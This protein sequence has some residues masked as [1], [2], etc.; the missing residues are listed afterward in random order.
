MTLCLRVLLFGIGMSSAL[1]GCT[2]GGAPEDLAPARSLGVSLSGNAVSTA[3]F[4]GR[5]LLACFWTT[6]DH[7]SRK[8]W[9]TVNS[10]QSELSPTGKF[11]IVLVDERDDED[12]VRAYV[13]RYSFHHVVVTLDP[14]GAALRD[15]GGLSVVPTELIFDPEGNLR[16]HRSG[17]GP[18][19]MQE[20]ADTIR[21]L[22]PPWDVR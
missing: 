11:A 8:T 20:L 5:T 14:D 16:Y 1:S 21:T 10:L 19:Q 15:N 9:P 6:W 4:R 18:E 13:E 22:V 7:A 12:S 3:D 2:G 17:Y